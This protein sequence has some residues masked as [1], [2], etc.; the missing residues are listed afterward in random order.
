[1]DT[2]AAKRTRGKEREELAQEL[3]RRVSGEVRFD[4]FSRILYSTDASIYQMEPV[5][6][7]I[8]RSVEDVVAVVEMARA[9]GV[10]VLPRGGGTALAGQTVNHAVVVDF[11]KYLNQLLEVNREEQWA[12]VRP[13]IVLE[14]L[15]KQLLAH[16]L[17]Y[18]PDPTTAN[19]AC[20]GGGIGNNTCGAHSVIYGK[21]LDH[22]KEVDAVLSDGSQSHFRSLEAHELETKLSAAGLESDIYRGMRRIARD[23]LTEIMARYPKIM[24]RVSGYNVDEFLDDDPFN[25]SRM[26]VGSEGTLCV[27][28]EAKVNL[29]P[30]PAMTALSVLHFTGIVEASEATREV[31]KHAPSSVE[32]MD[33]ILLDRS[34]ESLGH[35]RGTAFIEGDPGAL[36]VV[37]F[38]GESEAELTSKM[39]ALKEDM[40]RRR[41]GYACVNMLDQAAQASVWSLRRAGLGLLMSIRG[42][43]KPLPFVEDTAVDP[44]NLGEF[45]R[46]FDEIV[47]NHGTEAAYYGHASVGCL[48]VRPLVSLKD[49]QGVATMVSIAD[50]IS[51]LVGE[52]GGSLSGEHGDGIVR[53][54]W[55][56]KMFGP[57]I[58]Q[59]FREIKSTFDPQGIMN[60]GKI[61][62]CPPMTENL[63]FGP[64]YRSAPFSTRLDFS[65]DTGYADAVEMCNG[66]GACR[67]LDGSMCPSYMATREE[68]HSTRGRANLLRAA[69]S[70]RLPEGTITSERLFEAMDLCLACKACKAE[71]DS[72][73][74]MAK[75]KYEFL[76]RYFKAN[77]RPLRNKVFAHI[78]RVNRLGSKFAPFSNWAAR[79]PLGKLVAG[80]V[81]GVHSKRSLPP[82]TRETLPKWFNSRPKRDP[83]E[84]P[85][86]KGGIQGGRRV[87]LFND[88]FMNYNH[89]QV[90]RAAVDLLEAAGFSVEL[91]NAGCCGRPMISKGLLDEAAAQARYNVDLLH[92][93]AGQGIPIVGCEPSCLL[94]LRDEYPEFLRDEKSRVVAERAYMI[95]EFLMMLYDRGELELQF[96]DVPK[97]VLFHGHCHQKALAGTDSSMRA[98]RLPPGYQV[99]AVNAGCCG[100]AGSFGYEREHYQISMAIGEQALFP[101]VN[102]K[103]D[104]WEVAMT[105]V[106]C[107]Q[108][109]EQ[110][111]GRKARHLVE[112]L[113]DALA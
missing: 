25:L 67:K 10:P 113:R 82:F 62:D 98:L 105:G 93:Y 66:M 52:F 53:G 102:T 70:G 107:R 21:T 94:T 32:V 50:E 12:R 15:N 6:V 78:N 74:D 75:L 87:V 76:D 49:S 41:L 43:A 9:N 23:N 104:D 99:E 33:K 16:N 24:R 5:G 85:L 54:V 18:A 71:C 29:V 72:G 45:V 86:R 51:D 38:Y 111:T 17:Q 84:F 37:E 42:D 63:R 40:A 7:V 106:S 101:A 100:M 77:G 4:A 48:H 56:E 81:F 13:G 68:E 80:K 58:Y 97:K 59:M 83:P 20:V 55:T 103:G 47:R 57:E 11:S 96:Q 108:Q 65:L 8:P 34:R 79:S 92:A 22:V 109:I 26:V 36:L 112:V 95:E 19:R 91:A 73:V 30:R 44:E 31:L 46:R 64:D 14:E 88:T 89:P 110:G 3:R 61:I 60:P 27:V 28:T 2:P 1:M 69:L 35:S 90:G 39:N